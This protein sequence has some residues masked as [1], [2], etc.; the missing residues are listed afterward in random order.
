MRKTDYQL[1]QMSF[2][3]GDNT[4]STIARRPRPDDKE[5]KCFQT[6]L[7]AIQK[8]IY[9]AHSD[10]GIDIETYVYIS[11]GEY[12]MDCRR[13]LVHTETIE[14]DCSPFR[15][16]PARY[17]WYGAAVIDVESG[18]VIYHDDLYY[19][20]N[21]DQYAE[22][23]HNAMLDHNGCR[24]LEYSSKLTIRSIPECRDVRIL[25]EGEFLYADFLDDDRYV[26]CVDTSKRFRVID[27]V[28]A[29]VVI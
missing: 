11:P 14:E 16:S 15:P 3:I 25:A 23:K 19:R 28:T 1:S 29:K 20:G 18:A 10:G 5:L 24:L 7:E 6:A 17:A 27:T 8:K 21:V 4:V 2:Q 9:A 12:S 22:M 26:V 13:L